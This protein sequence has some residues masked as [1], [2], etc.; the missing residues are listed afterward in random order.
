[1]S[2]ENAF[3]DS[4]SSPPSG[5]NEARAEK[6]FPISGKG[7]KLAHEANS[8]FPLK[9]DFERMARRRFQNPK[10]FREGRW[11]WINPWQDEFTEGRLTRKRKRMKVAPATLSQREAQRVAAEML[12][13]MNQ[14]LDTIGSATQ[15][16]AYI[17]GTYRAAV[18]PLLASTTRHN[19][20]CILIKYLLHMFREASLREL[21]TITLQKHF[22]TMKASPATGARLGTCWQAF[23]V[24]RYGFGCW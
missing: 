16:G 1:M 23:S 12:R 6:P 19:C 17:A 13:P 22:S 24:A 9:G 8:G 20:E 2:S 10:P 15:F 3:C 4:G 21:D 7:D 11:W 18:L 14:G 5:P